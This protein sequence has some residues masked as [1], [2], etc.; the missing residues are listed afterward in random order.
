MG[1]ESTYKLVLRGDGTFVTTL[2]YS[3]WNAGDQCGGR[4]RDVSRT[5][6]G[7]Y[8]I[9]STGYVL[10]LTFTSVVEDGFDS[11]EDI[12]GISPAKELIGSTITI[13]LA[14]DGSALSYPRLQDQKLW[15]EYA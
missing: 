5:D 15:V 12:A 4:D 14:D 10:T 8:T 1:T 13:R 3:T 2:S 9:D 7:T 11:S 6:S